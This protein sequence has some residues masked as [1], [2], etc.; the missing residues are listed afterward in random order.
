MARRA[1]LPGGG[2][3]GGEGGETTTTFPP[4]PASTWCPEEF[5]EISVVD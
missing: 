1:G 3:G 4:L 2:G 5:L